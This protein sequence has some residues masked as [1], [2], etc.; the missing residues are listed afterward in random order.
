MSTVI[1]MQTRQKL[2]KKLATLAAS[3]ALIIFVATNLVNLGNLSFNLVFSRWMGPALF[4]DLTLLLTLKLA[5]LGMLDALQ[6]TICQRR[7]IWLTRIER[8]RR[9]CLF[10]M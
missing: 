4:G 5:M 9:A 7:K 10:P 2:N 6:A 1:P 3:P 8:L